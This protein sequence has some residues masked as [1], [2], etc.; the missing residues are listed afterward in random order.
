MMIQCGKVLWEL[1]G[2]RINY[3]KQKNIPIS[4]TAKH[5]IKSIL[6]PIILSNILFPI[7]SK[8]I[9]NSNQKKT[10]LTYPKLNYS[11]S[12]FIKNIIGFQAKRYHKVL[13]Q[14]QNNYK[15]LTNQKT[16]DACLYF[17]TLSENPKITTE[18]AKKQGI[19]LLKMQSFKCFNKSFKKAKIT[20]KQHLTFALFRNKK[21]INKLKKNP[22]MIKPL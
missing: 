20:E 8:L 17:Y 13:K 7:T 12:K 5:I 10:N 15:L 16:T 22:N 19:E 1:P 21:D 4:Q 6:A 9:S 18:K 3:L 2:L 14:R 11:C